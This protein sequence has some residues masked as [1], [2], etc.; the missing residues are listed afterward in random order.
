M[1]VHSKLP[2]MGSS[3]FSVMTQMATENNA[4]NLSQ[5]FPEF[6]VSQE[7]IDLVYRNMQIGH[8]QYAPMPGLPILREAIAGKIQHIGGVAINAD[9]EITVTV[10][11][12]EA[13][14]SSIMALVGKGDEVIVLEPA[15]DCYIP[16]IELAGATPVPIPLNQPDFSPNWQLIRESITSNT[17]ML[18]INY[19]HN[20]S[21]AILKLEDIVEL[22]QLL[23]DYP[24]LM[25]LSDEVYEHII[26][27][28]KE[29]LSVL[30]D[31]F[32][33]SRSVVVYSFGKTFHA[34]GWKIGYVVA[35]E[36]IMQEIRKVHQ[37]NCFTVN[38]PTQF[39]I[40]EYLQNE[41]NYLS[42]N[43]M[44]EK[45]R[46]FFANAVSASKFKVVPS[47][48]TYFQILSYDEVSD[49]PDM[50]FAEKLTREYGLASIPVSAFYSNKKDDHLLRFCFAKGEDTLQKAADILCRI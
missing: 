18:M 23:E 22:K 30:K 17:K 45:K 24:E 49:L 16:A 41:N 19:P 12:A 39:A 36:A 32:L 47:Y 4:L 31:V 10:G 48:G 50:E 40:A 9:S 44:Y 2:N 37:Y 21:G 20:P 28:G 6:P 11:A 33:A 13:I 7:L 43:D 46:D 1:P 14:F 8:N 42:L 3:I 26:F 38:T 34:T 29:H 25:L 35:P 5:G 27:D 15:Y